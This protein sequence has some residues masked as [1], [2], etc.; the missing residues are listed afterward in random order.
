[1]NLQMDPLGDSLKTRRIQMGW[2]ITIE[3]YPNW[4]FWCIDNP[5]RQFVNGSVPT[6]TRTRTD[7]P[8]PLVTL[9]CP[10]MLSNVIPITP[11]VL[12]NQLSKIQVPL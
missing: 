4:R 2:E 6:Q 10:N 5:D 9:W 3:L 8:E 1:M 12:P 11:M 7:G